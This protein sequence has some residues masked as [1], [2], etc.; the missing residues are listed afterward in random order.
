[1]AQHLV[2][3]LRS[4]GLNSI[5]AVAAAK[6]HLAL[7]FLN[8]N[9]IQVLAIHSNLAANTA[10]PQG[11]RFTIHTKTSTYSCFSFIQPAILQ[12]T[13][14]DVLAQLDA[15]TA[16]DVQQALERVISSEG[17]A[18]LP[19]TVIPTELEIN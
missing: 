11:I 1:M 10:A 5:L 14:F 3:Y 4:E 16:G 8:V 18:F 15:F 7:F 6:V 13:C 12:F 2:R 19:D 17:I 9:G